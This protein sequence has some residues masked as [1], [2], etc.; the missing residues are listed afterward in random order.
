MPDGLRLD[1]RKHTRSPFRPEE[2]DVR[3]FLADIGDE[4]FVR[5]AVSYRES[6]EAR[7]AADPEPFAKIAEEARER[8]VFLGC[9]CPTG[10]NP[11]VRRCHTWMALRFMAERFEGLE[12]RFPES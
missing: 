5:F 9:N 4:A 7:F 6:L 8:D 1:T 2:E 12:V 11:D 3:K 10:K